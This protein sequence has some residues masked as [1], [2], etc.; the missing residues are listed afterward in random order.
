MLTYRNEMA[1]IG[2][3]WSLNEDEALL[4]LQLTRPC[5]TASQIKLAFFMPHARPFLSAI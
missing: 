1:G 4:Y 5:F 3:K 2:V